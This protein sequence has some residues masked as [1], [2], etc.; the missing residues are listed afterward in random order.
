MEPNSGNSSGLAFGRFLLLPH[1]R[2]LLAGSQPVKLGGRA[3]DLLMALVE[4]RGAVL[5]KDA[6]MA[7]VWPDQIVE[8]NALQSQISALRA[9]FG[10]DRDLIRTVAGR[11]YQF[12]GEI[13][14]LTAGADTPAGAAKPGR[15]ASV[16]KTNVPEPVSELIGRKEILGEILSLAAAHRLVT[17]TGAGGIGK[18]RL[19]MAAA[20]QLLPDFADGVWLAELSPLTDPG[21]VT[22][23]VAAAVRLELGGGELSDQRLAQ[24]LADRELLLVL[25]TCE[26]VVTAV[27]PLAETVL[28]AGRF[29]RLLATSREPL[30]IE[31]EWVYQ[32]PP[33]AV[34]P[35]DAEGEDELLRYGA[36]R[37]FIERARAANPRFAP[38]H[39]VVASIAAVSR[40][41]DGIPL[42][43]EMAAAR[44]SALPVDE[45]AAR[46]KDRFHLLTA[47]RRTSL[48][49]HQTLRATLDWSYEL[50]VEPERVALRR[51]AVF[52]GPFSL[53]AA[54]SI[55]ANPP[56]LSQWQAVEALS[57]LAAKSLVVADVGDDSMPFRLLDT[58]RAYAGE[59]LDESGERA[60]LSRRHAGYYRDLFE[61]AEADMDARPAA[62]WRAEHGRAIDNLHAALDWAFSPDGDASIGVALT[63]AA[64]PLWLHLSLLDGCRRRVE[65]ALA[66]L[67]AG[68]KCDARR[69]MKL[70]AAFGA[71]LILTRPSP[72]KEVETALTRTLELADALDDS[73]YRL[74]AFH[75]L[76]FFHT[77]RGQHRTALELAHRFLAFAATR[78]NSNDRLVGERIIGTTSHF[79][80]DQQSARRHIERVLEDYAGSDHRSYLIRFQVELIEAA[81]AYLA[82][83]LWLLGFPD[84]AVRAA[85]R[86]IDDA[87][88][89]NHAN[90]LCHALAM[91]AC[92]I[93]RL[94]GDLDA[95]E[96]YHKMLLDHSRRYGLAAWHACGQIHQ[97]L[98]AIKRGNIA[99]GSELLRTSLDQIGGVGL[100]ERLVAFLDTTTETLAH[101]GKT[102]AALATLTATIEDL[103]RT[104]ERWLLP[105]LLRIKG[106]LLLSQDTSQE[107]VAAENYFRQALDLARRQRALSWELRAAT[108]L[109][110]LLSAECRPADA[111]AILQP[112]YDRF[113]EGLG[114]AD[115]KAAKALLDA[116]DSREE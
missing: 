46:L 108:S 38:P 93:A 112:V 81:R 58:T 88:V 43:I 116:L 47:Q 71:S 49:R 76:W 14:V 87:R 82:R 20:R 115:L 10:A 111:L 62:E 17:L 45:I 69:E 33:L 78:P 70:H 48:P 102:P 13:R 36:V 77:N 72:P 40:Q 2:A 12:T 53:E 24:A 31:G 3:F 85:E 44:A 61:R 28:R 97:G 75:G 91:T 18:T 60:T 86:A 63:A 73:E 7:Q 68:A 42:A 11:G 98:L 29:V 21:L 65:Q 34:P 32:V 37:L 99:A 50:L 39:R 114:T 107:I 96:H 66:A 15:A 83:T 74:R 67:A 90:P 22:A 100:L 106:E 101:N 103:E 52:A 79:L 35:E 23:A 16:V 92:P 54:S 55:I 89:V 8:E 26:H 109:A 84:Q 25:D 64:V 56:E 9:A 59:K 94:V 57:G 113:T 41:L 4:A 95:A 105:E 30:Q 80:G 5:G 104:E 19:A 1:R 6:L 51:L 110:R 27:A